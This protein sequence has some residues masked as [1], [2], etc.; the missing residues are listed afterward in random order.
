MSVYT[1][2]NPPLKL[3]DSR[4]GRIAEFDNKSLEYPM[5]ALVT[6]L[7]PRSKIW[8]I[9]QRLNQGQLP[10]C[11]GYSIAMEIGMQPYYHNVTDYLADILY[12]E[13][14]KIDYWPG[15]GYDGTSVL[16]GMITAKKLGFFHEF[17][18]AL[19]PNPLEDMIL[20][21]GNKGPVVCGTNWYQGMFTPD[22]SGFVHPT[23]AIVGGHAYVISQVNIGQGYFYSPNSWG[24]AGFKITFA[25]M[26]KLIHENGEVCIPVRRD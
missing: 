4:L 24:D 16:A 1:E 9:R 20:T 11:V 2:R 18:W 17:R 13:G 7:Y 8:N 5:R 26:D 19:P 10:R 15:E 3:V 23:G 21:V 22:A 6:G 14:Q 25:D 12:L